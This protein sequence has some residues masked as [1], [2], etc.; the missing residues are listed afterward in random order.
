MGWAGGWRRGEVRLRELLCAVLFKCSDRHFSRVRMHTRDFGMGR[1]ALVRPASSG[2]PLPPLTHT[3]SL[4]LSLSLCLSLYI[5]T[6][7][8]SF[9]GHPLIYLRIGYG[10][11]ATVLPFLTRTRMPMLRHWPEPRLIDELHSLYL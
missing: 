1:H 5:Y 8:Y 7:N 6:S 2:P 4:S 11:P 3:L 9:N 10:A